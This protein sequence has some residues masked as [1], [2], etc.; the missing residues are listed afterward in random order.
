MSSRKGLIITIDGPS[1][2]GKSTVARKLAERI[3]Y[4]YL[5]SGAMYRA[6]AYAYR[7]TGDQQEI[8]RFLGN[9]DLSFSFDEGA[10][11]CFNGED[12][13]TSIRSS[14]ISLAAS[15]ISQDPKVREYCTQL[16]R[17]LGEEGGV[18]LEGRD[19]GSVVFPHADRKF[20]LDANVAERARRRHVEVTASETGSDESFSK[21]Q[22]EIEK[23]DRDDS[24]RSLAPLIKPEG[25]VY[26]D[27]TEKGIDEVV[28]L[29]VK[30][31][32]ERP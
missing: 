6:V 14:E 11:V 26:V 10:K 5:D 30:A 17:R 7:A 1:G 32:G 28:D 12:I 15:R 4:R 9:L 22:A 24:S 29:L 3:G 18:V 13:S 27:T 23:R 20:F 16:Q 21:I 2:A 19:T 31:L 25:A 8:G